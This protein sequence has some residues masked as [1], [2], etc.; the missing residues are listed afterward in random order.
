MHPFRAG[1]LWRR[2]VGAIACYALA[3]QVA[4]SGLGPD[5][6]APAADPTAS[7]P[8]C[9]G[10]ARDATDR[11]SKPP[12]GEWPCACAAACV[13]SNLAS[14]PTVHGAAAPPAAAPTTLIASDRNAIARLPMRGPQ[15]ARAPPAV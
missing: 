5:P 15:L 10:H 2:I 11:S 7:A 9:S 13:G 1:R 4:L 3:V 12:R 8:I 14:A 6:A